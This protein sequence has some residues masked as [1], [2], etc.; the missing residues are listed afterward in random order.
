MRNINKTKSDANVG[1]KTAKSTVEPAQYNVVLPTTQSVDLIHAR[2]IRV[3]T[4][5]V[6]ISLE[7][8]LIPFYLLEHRHLVAWVHVNGRIW[9]QEFTLLKRRSKN[10][11]YLLATGPGGKMLKELYEQGIRYILIGGLTPEVEI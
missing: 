11:V 8:S 10:H 2:L 3:A 1:S 4:H 7:I 9:I 6:G 5:A